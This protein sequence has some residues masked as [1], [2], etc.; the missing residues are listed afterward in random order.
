MKESNLLKKIQIATTMVGARLFRVNAGMAWAG[1]LQTFS[2]HA[3]LKLNPGDRV[4]I[5]PRP[6]YGMPEGTPDLLGWT[7]KKLTLDDVGKTVSVFTA[8]EVKTPN[9]STTKAQK[10]FTEQVKKSGGYSGVARSE[11]DALV[12]V[13]GGINGNN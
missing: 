2:S 13:E 8:I 12:I 10:N 1:R 7:P 9:V 4:L 11:D 3:T 5:N 6:F